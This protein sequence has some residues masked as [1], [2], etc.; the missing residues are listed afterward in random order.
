MTAMPLP[1]LTSLVTLLI[2]VYYIA[3]GVYIGRVRGRVKIAA[4][5]MTGNSELERALRVQANAVEFAPILFPSLW[6]A[7]FWSGDARAAILGLVWLAGR[8]LYA[9][10]YYRDAAKRG[11]GFMIQALA[12]IAL[13]LLGFA[14]VVKSLAGA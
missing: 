11:P 14:G 5:A 8:V 7:A 9:L 10:S 12:V 4:P 13:A 3:I 2:I 6:L 1:P